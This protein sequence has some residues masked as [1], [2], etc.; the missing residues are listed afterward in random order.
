MLMFYSY[1]LQLK[2]DIKKIVTTMKYN[3]KYK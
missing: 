3:L 1:Q 2:N